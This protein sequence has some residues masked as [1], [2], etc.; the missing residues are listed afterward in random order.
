MSKALFYVF[1]LTFGLE[2]AYF[3]IF[4]GTPAVSHDNGNPFAFIPYLCMGAIVMWI[5]G[6]VGLFFAKREGLELR[7]FQKPDRIY[8]FAAFAAIGISFLALALS[9]PFNSIN[10]SFISMK[11]G[12]VGGVT[13]L[14]FALTIH[15]LLTLGEE[16]FWRGYLH[17]KLK[18]HGILKASLIIGP[19]WG[20]WHAP[21]ILMGH[22]YGSHP[23]AGLLLMVASTTA[24]SPIFFWFREKGKSILAPAVFHSAINSFGGFSFWL[25][26]NPNP[27]LTGTAGLAGLF[28][29]TVIST[30]LIFRDKRQL[31][32]AQ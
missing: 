26:L 14:V 23:Y 9:Y 21:L 20:I 2:G 32:N 25:Y 22:N 4:G 12:I 24:M 16:L 6:C 18:H 19:I 31:V 15:P 30:L 3:S 7:A 29:F 13:A 28:V 10:H 1:L 8:F 5:P 11:A 17:E 27:L